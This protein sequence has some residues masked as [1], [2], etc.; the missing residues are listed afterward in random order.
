MLRRGVMPDDDEAGLPP[1]CK[2]MLAQKQ[3]LLRF[4]KAQKTN[5]NSALDSQ[6]PGNVS[7]SRFSNTRAIT[8]ARTPNKSSLLTSPNDF[9]GWQAL[10]QHAQAVRTA[11]ATEEAARRRH[12]R[13][14]AALQHHHYQRQHDYLQY[15][16][17]YY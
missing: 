15:E 6:Q 10:R 5:R 16:Y 7:T 17:Q 13:T 4:V 2:L 8:H 3:Y 12:H 9:R 11:A 1:Q 14:A